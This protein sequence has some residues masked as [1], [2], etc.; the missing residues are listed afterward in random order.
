MRK[1]WFVR[2]GWFYRPVSVIGWA[3]TFGAAALCVWVAILADRHSHSARDS[4]S[5]SIETG[6]RSFADDDRNMAPSGLTPSTLAKQHEQARNIAS[7][8]VESRVSDHRS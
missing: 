8:T 2:F 6:G 4:V 7:Q 3:L 5:L 1:E